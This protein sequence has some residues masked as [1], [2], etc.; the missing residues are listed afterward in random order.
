MRYFH[1]FLTLELDPA[2]CSG[3][4]LCLDVCPH[5][6]FGFSEAPLKLMTLA[7][8]LISALGAVGCIIGIP[9][10]VAASPLGPALVL[11]SGMQMIGLGILG[12]YIARIHREVRGR[13]LYVARERL[14]FRRLP[15]PAP[16]ILEFLPG[17]EAESREQLA[18][19]RLEASR[20]QRS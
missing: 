1:E 4:K 12:E 7:G 5:G 10:V 18:A 20:F 6:V 11:L 3:C 13:P 2:K 15:K 9:G 8:L 17:R 16:N 19:A 14:G